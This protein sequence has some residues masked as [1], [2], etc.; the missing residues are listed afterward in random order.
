VVDGV[1]ITRVPA[2]SLQRIAQ[3]DLP[4][5]RKGT[6]L[7]L[8]TA[9]QPDLIYLASPFLLGN[10]V[11]KAANLYGAPIIAN[12]QTDVS[13]FIGFYGLKRATRLVEKRIAKIHKRVDLTLAPSTASIS[14]L[15]ELGVSRIK[16]W[17][18]GVDTD[19]FHP[20]RRSRSL[21]SQ[22]NVTDK[23]CV[24]GYVGRLA[25]EK[26]VEKLEKL[27]DLEHLLNRK[28]QIVV[29]GDG[30]SRKKLERKLPNAIFTGHVSGGELGTIMA[31]LD[32]LVITGENE[33]FCQ[34]I[35]EA[36]ASGV[37]VVAPRKGG[38]IDLIVEGVTGFFY[39]PGENNSIRKVT[40]QQIHDDKQ[41]R[42]MGIAAFQAVQNKTWVQ[43]CSEL[44]HIMAELVEKNHK[45]REKL[46][47]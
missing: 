5:V 25:P 15:R 41:R 26:Q 12:F 3:V 19:Q 42:L 17:G 2:V 13:G 18:R 9:W 39:K 24:V 43:L 27:A 16:Y 34:V 6:L 11:R 47:S 28:I 22:W 1:E 30:P 32:V 40:A 20:S 21:R 23:C 38:P 7:E 10:Q 35:Q 37:P 45:Q 14:W 33:T 36:M 4:K 46:A 44:E 31:S 8:M 29:V